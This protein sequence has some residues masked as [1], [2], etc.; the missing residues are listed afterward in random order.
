[1][2]LE[3]A[4]SVVQERGVTGLTFDAVSAASG[5]TRPG[6]MY[7]FPSRQALV[8]GVHRHLAELFERQLR[9]RLGRV[10]EQASAEERLAAYVRTCAQVTSRA[11]L[12]FMLDAAA[13]PAANEIWVE[14]N[15]RWLPD[16]ESI[17]EGPEAEFLFLVR[18]AADGL[19]MF[20]AAAGE[21][22]TA[23]QRDALMSALVEGIAVRSLSA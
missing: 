4:R 1:M 17:G 13:D 3:A 11:E 16:P 23:R 6:V 12:L 8:L 21:P 2:I 18:L 7:H 20:E 5:V 19:W 9:E 15:N 10:P 14:L 22:L